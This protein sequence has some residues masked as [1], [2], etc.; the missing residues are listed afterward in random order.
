MS[1]DDSGNKGNPWKSGGDKGPADLDA[2][3]RDLQRKLAGFLGGR[4]S[5]REGGD[6]GIGP[7]P[8]RSPGRGFVLGAAALLLGV[9]GLTGFY[10]VNAAEIGVVLRFGAFQSLSP[11]GLRWHIPW[12]I[13]QV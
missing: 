8:S 4:G 9:W 11:P 7:G 12:P 6:G 2:I 1:W 5:R 10:Q 3:V 13:E